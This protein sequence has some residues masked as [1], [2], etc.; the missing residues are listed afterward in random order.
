MLVRGERRRN[1]RPSP[2]T[3]AVKR[4]LDI[5]GSVVGVIVLSPVFGA[6]AIAIKLDS[7]GPVFF[8]QTRVGKGGRLFSIFKFRSM[9]VD[10]PQRGSALTVH[11]DKRITRVGHFLRRS[12]LDE[13]PQFLNVL[14][15]DMSLVGP[16]PEVPQFMEFYTPE[17]YAIMI[18]MR[19]GM[20]DYAAILFRDESSLLR[21]VADPV[22]VYRR[23][24]MPIKFS[25]YERYGRDIGIL[26]DLRIILATVLMI[27]IGWVP[28]WLGIEGELAGPTVLQESG[29]SARP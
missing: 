10:A 16:R 18:S 6:I 8:R 19:P 17:Q 5:I 21:H 7:H 3:L 11:A 23:Q 29:A 28:H 15:G 2:A 14:I 4:L 1:A 9:T 26:I 12:K 20:T 25:Y 13:L 24:I 27:A 22:E